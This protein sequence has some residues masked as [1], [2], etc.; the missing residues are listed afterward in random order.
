M[1][2]SEVPERLSPAGRRPRGR[3]RVF[4]SERCRL[5][6]RRARTAVDPAERREQIA[7]FATAVRAGIARRGLSLRDLEAVLVAEYGALASSVAT[8]SAWQTGASS[9]PRTPTGRSRVLAL[10]R[11]LGQPAGDLALLI[12]GGAAVPPP[13]PPAR[14]DGLACRHARLK[15]LVTDLAGPQQLLPVALT[16]D[17]RLGAS[18]RPLCAR[19]TMRVRA[20]HDG[21][22]R[23]WFLDA[24]DARLHP[25]VV[26]AT[27]CGMGRYVTEP[28]APA[29]VPADQ[30]LVAAEL[31]FDR[32]LAR[33]EHHE[34]SFLV[35]YDAELA[36][37]RMAEPLFRH[38]QV[39]PCERLDLTVSF[40]RRSIPAEVLAC[41]WRQRDL[42]EVWRQPK[43]R[44]GCLAYQLVI[45]DPVPGGYGWRWGWAPAL[46][47][48]AGV[49]IRRPRPGTSAA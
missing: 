9:P 44:P 27:G 24:S 22:D 38:V 13:R 40:D 36:A 11:C 28:E 33:G 15:H 14:L 5:G 2:G 6:D 43:T 4:C 45:T 46:D 31:L 10:E 3:P 35:Q 29:P 32:T 37:P 21:V 12:P 39:Q 23:Y 25:T 7:A 17:Y 34:F 16:K 48:V 20:A 19:I 41:R 42:I 47:S 26:E 8:L 49:G 30:R 1:C 18:R